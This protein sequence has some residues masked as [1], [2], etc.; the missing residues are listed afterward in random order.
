LALG[1]IQ[2]GLD[3]SERE[4]ELFQSQEIGASLLRVLQRYADV[5]T[6]IKTRIEQEL[7]AMG[8]AMK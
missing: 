2:S 8:A 1:T 4:K 5:L 3:F 6:K 7:P